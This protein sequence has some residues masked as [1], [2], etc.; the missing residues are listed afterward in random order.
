AAQQRPDPFQPSRLNPRQARGPGGEE[1][2]APALQ[3]YTVAAWRSSAS[4]S[5]I[6]FVDCSP[7]RSRTAIASSDS[8]S[9]QTTTYGIFSTSALR[10]RLPTVSSESSTSTRNSPRFSASALAASRWS[11]ADV[12]AASAP[13]LSRQRA[14]SFAMVEPDRDDPHLHGREPER[15][16]AAVMLD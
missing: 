10:I 7:P 15:E 5:S 1:H 2:V 16:R 13:R 4:N 14:G 3:N 8:L 9:P 12:A 11:R 6:D